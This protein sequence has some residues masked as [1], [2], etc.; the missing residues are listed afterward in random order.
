MRTRWAWQVIG[1][2]ACSVRSPC[3]APST[4]ADRVC[5]EWATHYCNRLE[6]CA[7]LSVQVGYGDVAG[8]IERSK[9]LC[10]S[11]LRADGTG[12]TTGRMESCALAYDS[13]GCEEVVVGKAPLRCGVPGSLPVGAEC[14][15]DS[16]CS[17][18]NGYCRIANDETCG[19]CAVLGPVGAGCYS[20]RDCEH[21]LV[22]YFTCMAPVAAGAACDG[23][24]RQCPATLM[25]FDYT[26]RAPAAPGA[27]CDPRADTCDRDHGLF[28]DPQAKRCTPYTVAEV[29]VPCGFATICRKGT[30]ATDPATQ[31]AT[32]VS[33]AADGARCDVAA[34]PFCTAPARC[35]DGACK[36]PDAASCR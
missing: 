30:C 34:G 3:G 26:C 35:V 33:N 28:C 14:G 16:Q 7:P 23:M 20:D 19:A 25:C 29:G 27:T 10:S 11:A 24:K 31:Q 6:S 15:D 9:P 21:G 36:L 8:C 17:G 2:A 4:G 18:P 5:T 13:A 12:Q 32:C 1:L 22:C